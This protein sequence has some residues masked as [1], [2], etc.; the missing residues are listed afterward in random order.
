MRT[1]KC[2]ASSGGNSGADISGG[3]DADEGERQLQRE[4]F[5]AQSDE[6]SQ[7]RNLAN[8]SGQHTYLTYC[9]TSYCGTPI[10]VPP[11]V[12]RLA[13]AAAARRHCIGVPRLRG[14]EALAAPPWPCMGEDFGP[15]EAG[16]LKCIMVLWGVTFRSGFPT[17]GA[18]M[19]FFNV[20]GQK[21]KGNRNNF[22]NFEPH[23][24]TKLRITMVLHQQPI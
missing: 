18:K 15:L 16:F 19:R 20:C 2:P 3:K 22:D 1:S 12:A 6:R 8:S 24:T 7:V 23:M 21:L 10:G 5:V 4:L 9:N 13:R 17:Y 14:V 11:C